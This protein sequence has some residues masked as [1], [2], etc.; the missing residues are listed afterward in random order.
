MLTVLL[1]K[2]LIGVSS[3]IEVYVTERAKYGTLSSDSIGFQILLSTT[4]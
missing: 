3:I 2:K 1:E 4:A